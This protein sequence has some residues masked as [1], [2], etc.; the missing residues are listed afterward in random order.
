MCSGHAAHSPHVQIITCTI[1]TLTERS[2]LHVRRGYTFCIRACQPLATKY[3]EPPPPPLT[4]SH[5]RQA[6]QTLKGKRQKVAEI[7]RSPD[8]GAEQS[9]TIG[10]LSAQPTRSPLKALCQR[11]VDVEVVVDGKADEE[12]PEEDCTAD[13]EADHLGVEP[14]QAHERAKPPLQ[15]RGVG[16][17][18]AWA[19]E[20][21]LV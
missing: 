13:E 20:T 7:G 1:N 16:K 15:T 11:L 3:K 4:L 21:G 2:R 8:Q 19:A 9:A 14:V 12:G 6:D 5:R 17:G 18:W 10:R